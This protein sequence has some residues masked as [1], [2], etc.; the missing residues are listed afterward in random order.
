MEYEY[1]PLEVKKGTLVLFHKNLMHTSGMNTS[2][3]SRIAY[4]FRII[5]GSM[6]CP[7]DSYTKPLDGNY[8]TL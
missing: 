1:Q 6:K 2:E 8:E 3:K 7:D 5:D 4:T